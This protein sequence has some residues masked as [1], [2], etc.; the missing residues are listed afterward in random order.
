MR[1]RSRVVSSK[2]GNE[3]IINPRQSA[4]DSFVNDNLNKRLFLRIHDDYICRVKVVG[5]GNVNDY[6]NILVKVTLVPKCI[7][8]VK[9]F[10]TFS[11]YLGKIRR[12]SSMKKGDKLYV[13]IYQLYDT[14]SVSKLLNRNKEEV[15]SNL[16]SINA[17]LRVANSRMSSIKL[18]ME[19]VD[20][21]KNKI[22]KEASKERRQVQKSSRG[23]SGSSAKEDNAGERRRPK[24]KSQT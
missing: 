21:I 24:K 10:F 9:K 20:A 5:K 18:G 7:S 8:S 13:G 22:K 23:N 6:N 3:K 12:I 19:F 17:S 15:D 2:I 14:E 16:I 4:L 11:D 1:K